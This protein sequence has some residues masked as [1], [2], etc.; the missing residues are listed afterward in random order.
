MFL[1]MFFFEC[2]YF[3]RQPSFYITGIVFFVLPLLMITVDRINFTDSNALKNSAYSIA[4]ALSIFSY[5][6][7][8]LVVNFVA[9]TATRN[10]SSEMEEIL[11]SKPITPFSY[12]LG[13]FLGSYFTIL[14][15]F[16]AVPI[17]LLVGTFMPWV[18]AELFGPTHLGNYLTG[19]LYLSVPTLFVLS[20]C[21]YALALRF[22]S[23][24]VVY[25]TAVALFIAY[26]ISDFLFVTPGFREVSALLD[27]FGG[28]TFEEITRYWTVHQKNNETLQLS[29]LFLQNRLLWLGI[30]FSV[31]WFFGG[32]KKSMS[33]HVSHAKTK[34]LDADISDIEVPTFDH[35]TQSDHEPAGRLISPVWKQFFARSKLEFKQVVLSPSFGILLLLTFFMLILMM[36]IP[37]GM[38]GTPIWP[39]TQTMVRLIQAAMGVLMM[40]IITYYSAEV[41]WGERSTGMGDIIDSMPV[42]NI[43]FWTSKLMAVWSVII[44]LVVFGMLVTISRQLISGHDNIHLSQYFVSLFFFSVLPW[45]MQAVLAFFLQ[46]L[47]PNKYVGMAAFVFYIFSSFAMEPLGLSH[48]LFNFSSSPAFTYSDMNGYGWA[49]ASHAWYMLYWGALSLALAIVGYGIWHRGPQQKL[50][51]RLAGLKYNLGIFGKTTFACAIAVFVM[52]GSY[53]HYNTRVLNDF[54]SESEFYDIQADYEKRYVQYLDAAV[55]TITKINANVEIYPEARKI[56]AQADIV[57]ENRS[58]EPIKRFLVSMP[59]YSP[60]S[61]V[62][63]EGASKL[64]HSPAESK[65]LPGPLNTYW[66]EFDEVLRPGEKRQGKMNVL[67]VHQGFVDSRPD[68]QLVKNGTFINN[69]ELFPNFG[70]QPMTELVDRNERR[71]RDLSPP[72]RAHKLEDKRYYEQNVMGPGNSFIDFEATVSTSLDQTAIAP[73]YLTR[74]WIEGERHF[75]HYKM[76]APMGHFYAFLSARLEVQRDEHDGVMIE[77]F[78]HASHKMNVARMVEAIKDSID[79]YSEN[80][81]PY[82]HRQARIIEFPG[83]RNFAQSFANTVPY[84]ERIGFFSDLRDSD[85]VDSVYFVTAHEMAHQWWGGQVNGANVQG[86]TMLSESLAHYS[87]LMVTEKKYGVGHTRKILQF[88]LDRYLRERTQ[89]TVE[90]LALMRVENQQ[91]IHYRKGVVAMAS[92]RETLGETRLHNILQRYLQTFKYKESPY[93]TTLDINAFLK[94]G[95][96]DT[97]SAFIKNVFEEITL[98]DFKL[99]EAESN[100]LDDGNYE[101]TLTINAAKISADGQGLETELG[102]SELVDIALFAID[103]EQINATDELPYLQKHLIKNGENIIKMIVP[104]LPKFAGI[105]PFV[106]Y[107]DRDLIDNSKAI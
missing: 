88:E 13:R 45:M 91:Y 32:F 100:K 23:M 18:D 75:F 15:V 79:Y 3:M 83:Y 104:T 53:I 90:E 55:P 50:R 69:T 61:S 40:I 107:I 10:H 17:G 34:K 67:R 97:E 38:F 46:V 74:D 65:N 78:H 27:P 66:F 95:A 101:V 102:L 35:A 99:S 43:V 33:V 21:F 94:D 63:I 9:N 81:G 71:R 72:K 64:V 11:Y 58:G 5:F 92:L 20:C 30:G 103:P 41:V 39:L 4:Q 73:G 42:N 93:P 98:Y 70:Y 85:E 51:H 29:G 14:L 87:A 59:D 6:A 47:S 52:T 106:K 8:F 68:L 16:C 22:Q 60:L 12:Q 7:M 48:N 84:S 28:Q 62:D 80:F 37:T 86:S 105:D 82:Q 89:E 96:S 1:K 57:V 19:F 44:V 24:M 26:E 2:R 36:T 76:D 31:M 54:I 77:V 56:V 49:L 25:L